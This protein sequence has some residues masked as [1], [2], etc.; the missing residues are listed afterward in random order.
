MGEA[1]TTF[2]E[3]WLLLTVC[4]GQITGRL[5]VNE[6][7]ALFRKAIATGLGPDLA[8]LVPQ[9]SGRSAAEAE[10]VCAAEIAHLCMA[11]LS[12][13]D[14]GDAEVREQLAVVKDECRGSSDDAVY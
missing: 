2:D 14:I 9:N 7:F 11:L 13:P 10:P 4:Q 5:A 3:L 8:R 12:Q 6:C 1:L